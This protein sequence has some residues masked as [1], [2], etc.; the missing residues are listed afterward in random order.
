MSGPALHA[1]EP[2]AA[3]LHIQYYGGCGGGGL[4]YTASG[5]H[6][7]STSANAP[8][9]VSSTVLP[10]CVMVT[11]LAGRLRVRVSEP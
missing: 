9:A 1:P 3:L 4:P 7:L 11:W 10:F 5:R 2:G 8:K 6:A